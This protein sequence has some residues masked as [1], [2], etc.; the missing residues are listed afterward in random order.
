MGTRLV[1]DLKLCLLCR[2]HKNQY[3]KQQVH[4]NKTLVQ[5]KQKLMTGKSNIKEV[6]VKVKKS[7]NRPGVA[8]RVTGVLGSQ[9]S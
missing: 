1:A 2:Q 9:I 7:R 5:T 6:K 3:K 8:Q 4:K